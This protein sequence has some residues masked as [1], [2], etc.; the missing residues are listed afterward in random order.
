[1][2]S[3]WCLT[4]LSSGNHI[5]FVCPLNPACLLGRILE[6]SL[7]TATLIMTW[8]CTYCVW[9]WGSACRALKEVSLV[10]RSLCIS[11]AL[12]EA[13]WNFTENQNL[14]TGEWYVETLCKFPPILNDCFWGKPKC[15]AKAQPWSG[16]WKFY[17]FR[18]FTT[19]YGFLFFGVHSFA[20]NLPTMLPCSDTNNLLVNSRQTANVH[21]I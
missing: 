17:L 3:N 11:T 9:I 18:K 1:M 21:G 2:M 20:Q 12:S 13:L 15:M 14:R 16:K 6:T 4:L 8:W 10:Q 7:K 5:K 19:L